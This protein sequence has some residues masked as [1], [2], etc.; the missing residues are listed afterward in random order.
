MK[1]P[2]LPDG[3]K[4]GAGVQDSGT[5]EDPHQGNDASRVIL[6]GMRGDEGHRIYDIPANTRIADIV[7]FFEV[8]S[9][10]AQSYSWDPAE[11]V[12]LV[13]DKMEGINRIIPGRVTF[14][15]A[16][17]FKFRFSRQITE[18]DLCKIEALIPDNE[19]MQAGLELY[20]SEWDGSSR[21]LE[22]VRRDNLIHLWWD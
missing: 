10:G 6:I 2:K 8:G 22:A 3:W 4:I 15:D 5:Y 14:A 7:R 17:G 21:L 18:D 11:T 12:E 13:A 16:G 19:A 20:I 1:A 9:H